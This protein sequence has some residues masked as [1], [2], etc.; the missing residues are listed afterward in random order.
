MPQI[1][2]PA[3]QARP[4]GRFMEGMRH[5]IDLPPVVVPRF[6][7]GWGSSQAKDGLPKGIRKP[8]IRKFIELVII[9]NYHL[10]RKNTSFR[11]VIWRGHLWGGRF[12]MSGV[13]VRLVAGGNGWESSD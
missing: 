9:N 6:K 13:G 10:S 4:G 12:Q 11:F 7:L 8:G 1:M 3:L 5:G 2:Q